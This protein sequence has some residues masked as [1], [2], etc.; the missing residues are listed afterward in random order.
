MVNSKTRYDHVEAAKIG[1]GKVQVMFDNLNLGFAP[2]SLACGF[3]HCGR[4]VECNALCV[5]PLNPEQRQQATIP[6]S[7]IENSLDLL[8]DELKQNSLA[9][10]AMWNAIGPRQIS[11]RMRG[12]CVFV[13]IRGTRHVCA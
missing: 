4:K 9:F 1:E 10:R 8:R 12:G 13:A 6:D 7:Q 3:Q 11:K 2:K 5:A